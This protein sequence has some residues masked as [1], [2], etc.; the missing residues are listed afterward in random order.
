[1]LLK[2][3]FKKIEP[4]SGAIIMAIGIFLVGAIE[5]FPFLNDQLGNYLAFLLMITWIIIYK[6]LSVQF[7]H[8][9][10]LIPF[11]THPVN[12]FTIGTWIAGVSV[13]CNVF[14]KYFPRIIIVTQAMTIFNTFLWLFFLVICFYNFKQLL[15]DHQDYPV[16][17]ILLMSTVGT[18]S[19]IVLLNNVFL[20]FPIILSQSIII[21]GLIFYSIGIILIVK[22]YVL[23]KE[24]T[25][26]DDWTNTNCIAHGALS[27]TGLAIVSSNTFTSSFVTAL[28]VTIFILLVIIEIIEIIRAILRVKRYG[29]NKGLCNYHISQWSRNFTFG[30]FYT[31]TLFIHRNPSYLVPI[32]LQAF[33]DRFQSFWAWVVMIALLAQ[34]SLYVKSRLEKSTLSDKIPTKV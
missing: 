23:E 14:L 34:I 3:N 7:F 32:R 31:F 10:F 15:F 22:R 18:Q 1:M 19:I 33:Q 9:K 25:L 8:R 28:W 6:R 29:W 17:G 13:L 11:I 27:I 5:A 24:W 21:L 4:A 12:S 2:A 30:M 16:H 20:Q 26:V